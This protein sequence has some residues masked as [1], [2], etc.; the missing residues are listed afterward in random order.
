MREGERGRK[1]VSVWPSSYFSILIQHSL[2]NVWI[3]IIYNLT[4]IKIINVFT[5]IIVGVCLNCISIIN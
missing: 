1:K 4:I 3:I 5:E 2:I